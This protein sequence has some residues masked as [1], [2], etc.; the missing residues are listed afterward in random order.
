MAEWHSIVH[1][2]HIFLTHSSVDRH[3]GCFHVF[4]IMN[5]AAMNIGVHVN[6]LMKVLSIYR[7]GSGIAGLYDSFIF[8]FLISTV[9]VPT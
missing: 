5:N 7:P 8:S 2:Y 3:L 6:F 1:M 4:A 9:V